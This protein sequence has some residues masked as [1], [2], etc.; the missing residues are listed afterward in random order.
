MESA[1]RI[2]LLVVDDDDVFRTR[3]VAALNERGCD[4]IGASTVSSALEEARRSEPECAIVD[5]RIAGSGLDLVSALRTVSDQIRI[6]VL[7][8]Y[9]SIAT[10]VEAV[11]RGAMNYLTKPADV[12]TI[13]RSLFGHST[14]A[15]TVVVPQSLEQVEWEHINRVLQECNGNISNAAKVL[16]LHRRS[17]QRKLSAVTRR[18]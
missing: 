7:T 14:A 4:A 6:V 9:G 3:L 15:D 16:G 1:D 11:R 2:A 5:L 8:G 12:E 18:A 17:L 10:A 13:L